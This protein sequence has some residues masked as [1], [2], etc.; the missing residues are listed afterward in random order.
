VRRDRPWRAAG[1][2]TDEREQLEEADGPG[3]EAEAAP[4]G[5]QS[6]YEWEPPSPGSREEIDCSCQE[7]QQTRDQDEL[8]RP[9][10]DESRADVDVARRSLCELASLVERPDRV[11]CGAAD[12]AEAAGAQPAERVGHRIRGPV[13]GRR[14]RDGRDSLR[15]ERCLLVERERKAEVDE[16]VER[17][18]PRR[19]LADLRGNARRDRLEERAGR[20]SWRIAVELQAH[21][22]GAP[23]RVE[24]D[25]RGDVVPAGRMR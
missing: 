4:I 13:A 7:R 1:P 12:L 22:A 23:D 8:H 25:D 6:R 3:P 15:E 10:A 9:P 18:R 14:D 20:C 21:W 16:L 11:L 24:V 2:H 17:T 19:A 5:A